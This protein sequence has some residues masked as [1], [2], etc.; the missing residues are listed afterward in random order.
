AHVLGDL[1]GQRLHRAAELAVE[2]Q[3]EV[4]LGHRVGRELDVDHGTDDREDA[5][6]RKILPGAAGVGGERLCHGMF[7]AGCGQERWASASAPPT[8]SEIS[9][10]IADW[11]ARLASRVS[12]SRTSPALSV[13]AFIARCRLACSEAAD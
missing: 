5:T 8:I 11:R 4:D 9:V 13:A 2:L 3:G 6:L 10:V 1:R 7:S 12:S